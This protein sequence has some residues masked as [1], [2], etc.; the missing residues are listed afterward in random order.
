[1]DEVST[2]GWV[3][4]LAKVAEDLSEFERGVSVKGPSLSHISKTD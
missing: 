3:V 4:G 2:C 1:M